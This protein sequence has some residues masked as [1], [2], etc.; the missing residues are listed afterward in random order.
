M[1]RFDLNQPLRDTI[2]AAVEIGVADAV[3]VATLFATHFN[4]E[5]NDEGQAIEAVLSALD[6]YADSYRHVDRNLRSAWIEIRS[7]LRFFLANEHDK[8]MMETAYANFNAQISRYAPGV[9]SHR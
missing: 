4:G 8:D 7:A 2:N 1:D 5:G 3:D 9:N 6:G